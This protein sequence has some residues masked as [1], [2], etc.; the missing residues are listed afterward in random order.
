MS[1]ERAME[2][3]GFEVIAVNYFGS[4]QGTLLAKV[5]GHGV[6][7]YIEESYGSCSGC[8]QL[9]A[10]LGYEDDP[11]ELKLKGFGEANYDADSVV[12]A[13]ELLRQLR[14]RD[15]WDSTAQEMITWVEEQEK[16]GKSV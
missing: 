12:S 8:D 14:E 7:G 11:E 6:S 13:E 16:A 1:Y 10:T 4:Y 2:L 5:S 15:E 9:E 3:A